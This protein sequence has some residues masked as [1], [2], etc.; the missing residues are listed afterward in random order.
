MKTYKVNGF[1]HGRWSHQFDDLIIELEDDE[2]ED[3][4]QEALWG[5]IYENLDLETV[6]THVTYVEIKNED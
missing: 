3:D 1:K 5:I 6:D 2:D 4:L